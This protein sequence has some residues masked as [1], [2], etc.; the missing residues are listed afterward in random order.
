MRDP[1]E[2]TFESLKTIFDLLYTY[3]KCYTGSPFTEGVMN[4]MIQGLSIFS[5]RIV[6]VDAS[7]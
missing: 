2:V 3:T 4:A 1:V 7:M 5:A 6:T